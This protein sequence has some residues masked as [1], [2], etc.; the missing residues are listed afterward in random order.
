MRQ[1][2]SLTILILTSF[3]I[4]G[5]QAFAQTKTDVRFMVLTDIHFNP[6]VAC[7]SPKQSPCPLISKLRKAPASAWPQLLAAGDTSK[8]E[9]HQNTNYKLLTTVL[10]QAGQ[11]ALGQN[12][13]YILVL[14]DFLS[15]DFR[16]NYK[17]FSLDKSRAGYESFVH[18][19]LLFISNQIAKAFPEQD[20]YMVV[21]NN[22]SYHRDYYVTPRGLFFS[23]MASAWSDLIKNQ[24]NR[25]T[26][27]REFPLAGYYAVNLPDAPSLRLIVLNTVL[28]SNKA[29]GN[30]LHKAADTELDWLH[31]QLAAAR[32]NNQHVL[33]AMHIPDGIDVYTSLRIRL[34]RAVDLWQPEYIE[35]FHDELREYAPE[36]A[37]MYAGH[38]HANWLHALRFE[39]LT[40]VLFVG[41]ASVSPIYG[42][43]PGFS[44]YQY[45]LPQAKLTDILT[46]NHPLNVTGGWKVSFHHPSSAYVYHVA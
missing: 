7:Q 14:G 41:T 44:I 13:R 22:D 43:D 42:N 38:L 2:I 25:A 39:N 20:V 29:M 4:A 45:T 10:D 8:P 33:I 1:W 12:V 9:Y 37:G 28:F 5:A 23:Q 40:E 11:E 16:H 3:S 15:H 21:G 30:H 26:M 46:Y 17:F 32:K 36:I 19:T 24:E 6:Y 18:K 27:R 35:R 34:L 31:Q